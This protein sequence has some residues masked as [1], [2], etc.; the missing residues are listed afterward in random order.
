[1]PSIHP[2]PAF[3]NRG[4]ILPGQ[5]GAPLESAQPNPMQ[6]SVFLFALILVFIRFSM[7]HQ[8]QATVMGVNLYLLY[9]FGIPAVFGVLASGGVRR[10]FLRRPG[11]YW[12]LFA[13]WL[14]IAL[15]FSSWKGGSVPVVIT[16]LRTDFLMLFIIAGATVTWRDCRRMMTAIALAAVVSVSVSKLFSHIDTGER[17]QLTFGTVANS[18]DY[19]AHLILVLPFLLWVILSR[20]PLV[21]RIVSLALIPYGIYVILATASRGALVAIGI[22]VL[23]AIL[24]ATSRQRIAMLAVIPIM[25]MTAISFVP[26]N[27]WQRLLSFSDSAGASEEA[28]ESSEMRQYL[29][30]TSLLY[31]IQHP[32]FG[33][34]AG[35]FSDVE[36]TN[37]RKKGELGA[38][39]DTHNTYTQIA[40]ENGIPALFFFLAGIVTSMRLLTRVYRTAKNRPEFR[41][42][43]STAFCLMLSLVSFCTAIFF[44][45]FGYFFYLPAMSGLAMSVSIAAEAEFRKAAAAGPATAVQPSPG[46]HAWLPPRNRPQRTPPP[47]TAPLGSQTRLW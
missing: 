23:Y 33:V 26:R 39:H 19:A 32:L 43:A 20:T 12:T 34:G 9:I 18:N 10:I 7:L 44:L 1:M 8:I 38:W 31:T 27:A 45:N 4:G 3:A 35:Q 13:V 37:S 29:L 2:S 40:S 24:V 21:F 36:G 30:R 5:V 14:T 6:R 41:E 15:P 46:P 16:Y 25:L 28:R 11:V 22:G 47:R 42:I 17:M